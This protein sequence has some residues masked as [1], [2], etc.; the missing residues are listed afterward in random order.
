MLNMVTVCVSYACAILYVYETKFFFSR[1]YVS[2]TFSVIF[3]GCGR[4]F[5]SL[6]L[7]CSVL[8]HSCFAIAKDI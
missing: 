5:N 4:L 1:F 2:F 8:W 6:P 3:Y 7:D